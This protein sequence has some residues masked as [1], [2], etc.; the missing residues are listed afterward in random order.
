MRAANLLLKFVLEVAAFAAFADWGSGL[1]GT[2][3][4]VAVAIAAPLVAVVL[5]GVLAAPR[6]THRLRTAARIPFELA[7]FAL[8]AVAL[9]TADQPAL[10]VAFASLVVVNSLLL[11]LYRQWGH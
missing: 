8:A 4:S 7:V 2:A 11:T 3:A 5:W 9:A 1:D 6:S 10:A